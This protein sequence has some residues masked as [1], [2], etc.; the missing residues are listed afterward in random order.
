MRALAGESAEVC[1]WRR[2]SACSP[3]STRDRV[4]ARACRRL[5]IACSPAF[6]GATVCGRGIDPAGGS[7][8]I[9]I[10]GAGRQPGL[11]LQEMADSTLRRLILRLRFAL[12]IGFPALL[13]L[14][15]GIVGFF[16][17]S[18]FIPLIALIQGLS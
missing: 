8:G 17:I 15:G 16:V 4:S 1:R 3:R 7:G 2:C 6:T 10:R 13:L 11:A 9:E 18:L 5:V 14:F 12:A